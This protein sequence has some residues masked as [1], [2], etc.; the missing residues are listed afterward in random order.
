MDKVI[1]YLIEILIRLKKWDRAKTA[2]ELK[3]LSHFLVRQVF[4]Q[5]PGVS[6]IAALIVG[7][8]VASTFTTSPLKATLASW[9]LIKGGTHVVSGHMYRFLSIFLPILVAGFT[10]YLVQKILKSFREKQMQRNIVKISQLGKDV[11]ALLQERL[12][13]LEKAK[14]TGLLS[15]SEYL[16]K[17][18]NLYATYSRILP[19]QIK[20][21]LIS[22]LTG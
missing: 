6:A 22:K 17:K 20:E 18:A 2:I 5:I 8:W 16:T 10:V 19:T 7:G 9:G 13:I 12:I 14:E 3:E 15:N 21:L 1:D 4:N 11:Q